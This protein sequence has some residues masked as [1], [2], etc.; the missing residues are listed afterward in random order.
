MLGLMFEYKN[1]RNSLDD[2][3]TYISKT[4]SLS[5]Y[6]GNEWEEVW[7]GVTMLD[8]QASNLSTVILDNGT[9][10]LQNFV[11]LKLHYTF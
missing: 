5:Y 7:C 1:L 3:V 9:S 6:I 10:H 4:S 11:L 2:A 8:L